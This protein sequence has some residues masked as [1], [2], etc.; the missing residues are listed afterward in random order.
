MSTN[1]VKT[2]KSWFGNYSY[3][4]VTKF[5]VRRCRSQEEKAEAKRAGYRYMTTR[6]LKSELAIYRGHDIEI[7]FEREGR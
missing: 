1:Y 3:E 6:E 2:E 7:V 5:L 4:K